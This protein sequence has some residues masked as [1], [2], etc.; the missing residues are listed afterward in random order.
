MKRHLTYFD[1]ILQ[2]DF[3]IPAFEEVTPSILREEH[4]DEVYR[5][6]YTSLAR[7]EINPDWNKI[8]CFSMNGVIFE[9]DRGNHEE[10]LNNCLSYFTGSEEFEI[11]AHLVRLKKTLQII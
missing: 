8:P 11:C 7:L 2:A 9:I 4:D 10:H 3:K 6:I 1:E 5:A